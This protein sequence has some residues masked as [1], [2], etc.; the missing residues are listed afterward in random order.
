[1]EGEDKPYTLRGKAYRRSDT[2]TMEVDRLA[3]S[4]LVLEGSG[5][6]FEELPTKNQKPQFTVLSRLPEARCFYLDKSNMAYLKNTA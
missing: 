2:S 1:M 4:R 5:K 3:F 6:N